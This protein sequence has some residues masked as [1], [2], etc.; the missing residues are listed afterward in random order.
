MAN[1]QISD[2]VET[3]EINDDDLLH[4]QQAGVDKKI[5]GSNL[6]GITSSGITTI[7]D[8]YV[9]STDYT[10]G[11]TNSVNI[12][13]SVNSK[14]STLVYFDGIYQE[15]TTYN[16]SGTLL[17][18]TS[19]IPI[20]VAKVEVVQPTVVGD[21]GGVI[22][23]NN[24]LRVATAGQTLFNLSTFTYTPGTKNLAVY[25]NGVRLS[26]NEYAET[27]T[28]SVTLNVGV[29]LNDEVLFTANEQ[30][31]SQDAVSGQNVTYTP[32]NQAQ[33]NVSDFLNSY[34]YTGTGS[35]EG[36]VTA[37]VPAI[38]LRLDGGASTTLYVKESGVGNTGWAA[39]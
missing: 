22:A 38:F 6:L 17:T 30:A 3:T 32:N 4:L 18:F 39:K 21:A 13:V 25:V 10:P 33:T 35:P 14:N 16:V 29:N 2:F 7:V 24:E 28:S 27:S 26:N 36:V 34:V 20:G 15:K 1:K 8:T 23:V 37:S 9:A 12:S 5:T 19:A 11:V 31:V